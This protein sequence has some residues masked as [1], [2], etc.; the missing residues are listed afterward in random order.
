[1][2]LDRRVTLRCLVEDLTADW[3]NADHH[4][5]AK[6]L[7]AIIERCIAGE[8]P[9]TSVAAQL[10]RMPR[11]NSLDHPL[12]R[13][14]DAAFDLDTGSESRESISG[15]SSPHWW[16]QKTARWRGAATDHSVV[17]ENA[18]WLCAAGI[19]RQGDADDFYAAFMRDINRAGPEPWLPAQEDHLAGKVDAKVLAFDAWKLQIHC[20]ALAVLA[21]AL[22]NPGE[23]YSVEFPA[24][25]RSSSG[26]SVGKLSMSVESVDV[27]GMELG[28]V[29]LI[30][31]ILNREQVVAVDLAVQIARAAIQSDAEEWRSTPYI[32][33]S[34]SFSALIDP[35]A[36][37]HAVKLALSGS[38]P[39]ES[40]PGGL[41]I[42]LRA[43]YARKHGLVD[44]QVEGLAVLSLC[45]Y[46]FVPTADHMSLETCSECSQR[47][48]QMGVV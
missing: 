46:W 13:H 8:V 28:E 34:Y 30:G 6:A 2:L 4:R 16:K 11:L 36:R 23:T 45:G 32:G 47:H 19:R 22:E 18:V 5:D 26:D 21:E 20:S 35:A 38:L 9:E 14:F 10:R 24:P 31:S 1:M 44:A 12:L 41:R 3:H 33:E 17:G 39:E 25:S 40:A 15:L 43:H 42:G 48:D 27:D 37:A 29:F 7:R